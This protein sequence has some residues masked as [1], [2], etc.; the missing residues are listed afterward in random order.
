MTPSGQVSVARDKDRARRNAAVDASH[1]APVATLLSVRCRVGEEHSREHGGG[2]LRGN[3]RPWARVAVL[4]LALTG[5]AAPLPAAAVS[6]ELDDV[7]ADR[8]ERKRRAAVGQLPLPGTPDLARL[9]E[10]LQEAR[11]SAGAAVLLRVFKATSEL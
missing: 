6:I 10:R 8:I 2:M 5:A 1:T 3:R 7:A 4:G 9:P 11:V